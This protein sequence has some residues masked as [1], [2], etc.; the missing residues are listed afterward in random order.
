VNGIKHHFKA[1]DYRV[2]PAFMQELRAAQTQ[3]E[4]LSPAVIE[5]LVL[6]AA[7]ENEVC[8]MKWREIDWQERVWTL[9]L[10]RDKVGHKPQA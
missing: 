10:E 6:T 3:G 7:R 8:W 1:I 9:P 2:M 5:F 4:A